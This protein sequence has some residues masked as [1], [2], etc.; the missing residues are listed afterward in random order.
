M[1]YG[2]ISTI[3][4][5]C[6]ANIFVLVYFSHDWVWCYGVAED[7]ILEIIIYEKEIADAEQIICQELKLREDQLRVL[8]LDEPPVISLLGGF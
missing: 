7:K 3:R 5:C 6:K 2:I 8:L 1:I 4:K